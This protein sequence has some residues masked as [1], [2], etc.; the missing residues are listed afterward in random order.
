[1]P[2]GISLHSVLFRNLKLLWDPC[3]T[4]TKEIEE[5]QIFER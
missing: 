4:Q 1:M 5:I 2:Y 3:L